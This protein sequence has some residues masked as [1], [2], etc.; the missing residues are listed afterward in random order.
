MG[1]DILSN[2]SGE[3]AL[4]E[5]NDESC[6][7]DVLLSTLSTSLAS[8]DRFQVISAL[9]VLTKLCQNEINEDF[10]ETVLLDQSTVYS[11]LV[12]Y[13]SLHD[14]HL[15]IATLECLYSLT[16]LG[17]NACNSIVRTHGALDALVSLITVE[18][19]SYG[20]KACILMRVVETVPGTT[21]GQM[22][23]VQQLHAMTPLRPHPQAQ[24]LLIQ[25]QQG[26]PQQ[27]VKLVAGQMV[28]PQSG[29]VVR[30]GGQAVNVIRGPLVP[31]VVQQGAVLQLPRHPL[32]ILARTTTPQQQQQSAIASQQPQQQRLMAPVGAQ[33]AIQPRL[34]APQT[35]QQLQQQQ[36]QHV[37][38][39]IC[40][41]DANRNFCLSWLRTTY[42][43][44]A[45]STIPQ[46]IMYKQYLASLH[47]LGRKFV[48][49][50]DHYAACVR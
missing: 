6:V 44:A 15:L 33:Q 27:Q 36:G 8:A 7:T 1:F 32:P 16:C 25:K 31:A 45:G 29:Q 38:L 46:A 41:D 26:Q 13:L 37:Q 34:I 48:I 47:R 20:P 39:R 9:E 3:I 12:T 43:A 30:A 14:I 42:E 23:P 17:E 22:M 35:A 4:E 5:R 2:I 24:Q 21:S 10:I 19:Q 50:S 49:A 40:N 11:Q 18:A 28:A